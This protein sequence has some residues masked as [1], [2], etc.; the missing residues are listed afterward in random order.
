MNISFLHKPLG[1]LIFIVILGVIICKPIGC[2]INAIET[3]IIKKINP[4][5]ITYREAAK[6]EKIEQVKIA[7]EKARRK[8]DIEERLAKKLEIKKLTNFGL[9]PELLFVN[10]KEVLAVVYLEKF[11]HVVLV[12]TIDGGEN[13]ETIL[14][15]NEN[16]FF[17]YLSIK[18]INGKK[19]ITVYL[20]FTRAIYATSED[21]G[22]TWI[23]FNGCGEDIGYPPMKNGKILVHLP[24][25]K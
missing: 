4:E 14:S 21:E 11:G 16:Q 1:F 24:I 5:Y 23:F 9:G 10:N 3:G 6:K 12:K 7:G 19:T 17:G 8:K 18:P 20:D 15:S 25:L 13:W 2:T 22:K